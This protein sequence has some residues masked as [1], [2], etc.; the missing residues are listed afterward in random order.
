MAVA[1]GMDTGAKAIGGIVFGAVLIAVV[2]NGLIA[3]Q[4]LSEKS[5]AEIDSR[6]LVQVI[7]TIDQKDAAMIQINFGRRYDAI[8]ITNSTITLSEGGATVESPI[9]INSSIRGRTL[10]GAGRLCLKQNGTLWIQQTCAAAGMDASWRDIAHT[11]PE[12][13]GAHPSGTVI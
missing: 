9:A 3:S 1:G 7:E 2:I 10:A 11:G 12:R 4:S 5:S 13:P 6:R 8:E